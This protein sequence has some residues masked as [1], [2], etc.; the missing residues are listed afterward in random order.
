M[1]PLLRVLCATS[2]SLGLGLGCSSSESATPEGASGAAGESGANGD[3]GAPALPPLLGT[4]TLS[5]KPAS[6][7]TMS[8]AFS[9][10]GG[11]VYDG[12]VPEAFPL[13]VALEEQGC[14]LRKPAL[15]FCSAGCGGG[16]AC[17]DDETCAPYPK[18][19]NVG[20]LRLEGL[21]SEPVTMEPFPPGFAYQS[22]ALPHPPCVEGAA[23]RLNADGFSAATVCIAPLV[24]SNSAFPVQRGQALKLSWEAPAQA[25]QTRLLIKLDVSHHGGKKGEIDCDVPDTGVLEIP[26][27]LITALVDLGLAGYPTIVLTRIASAPSPDQP[28]IEFAISSGIEREVDTGITSCTDDAQ[29]PTGQ[30]CNTDKLTCE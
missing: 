13:T 22:K 3:A 17:V 20:V 10:A 9:V 4:V 26:A 18:A 25:D 12:L 8:E 1:K 5:L 7:A 24:V 30:L 27:T 23:V 6:E 16:A 14:Q 21:G 29:C 11:T 28:G 2:L 19:Q 15:P